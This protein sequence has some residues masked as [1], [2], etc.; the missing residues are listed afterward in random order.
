MAG[1]EQNP[2]LVTQAASEVA[3]E[4][5]HLLAFFISNLRRIGV[6]VALCLCLAVGYGV[7]TWHANAQLTKAHK[8]LGAILVMASDAERLV[9]LKAFAATAPSKMQDGLQLALARTALLVKEYPVA[10]A[11]WDALTKNPKAPIY[12]VAVIGKA[13]SLA[14]EDKEKEAIAFLSGIKLPEGGEAMV[15]VDSL[16]V[17]FAEKI[18]DFPKA[19]AASEKLVST[20]AS[21]G[22]EEADFWRRKAASLRLAQNAAA[23]KQ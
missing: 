18:G 6:A 19:I 15:L 12:V 11:A 1:S 14:L 13:E 2:T 20:V 10:T 9:A 22:P 4:S 5:S 16:I 17:D 8:E 23:A 3:P 7:Y 21:R